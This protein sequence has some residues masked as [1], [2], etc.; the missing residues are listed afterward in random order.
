MS[1]IRNH[2]NRA[3]EMAEMA[4]VARLKGQGDDA[5]GFFRRALEFELMAIKEAEASGRVE[6]TYSVLQRSAAT[7]ALDCND[8]RGAERIVAKALAQ[9]PPTEIAE[10]LRDI[11]EQVNFRRHLELKGITLEEDELQMNLS[12]RGVGY[13]LVK[14][15]EFLNRVENTSK[16][17]FRIVERRRNKPFREKGRLTSGLKEDYELFVSVP[18]AASF[19]VTLKLG[20]PTAQQKLPGILETASIVDEFMDLM[21]LANQNKM[22]DI[23][24]RIPDPA[25]FRNFVALAKKVA[26]DGDTV[27]QVGFTAVHS[28]RQRL[29]Q[30]TRPAPDFQL[31]PVDAKLGL[32]ELV[33]VKGVLRYA[34]ATHGDSGLIKVV[35]DGGS[36]T[37]TIKVPEGMMADIVRP[38]WDSLV[39]VKGR[40]EGRVITLEDIQEE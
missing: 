27:Q 34:D 12:G 37:H 17:I 1:A 11:L 29:V 7:L 15:V 3:M 16:A 8:T 22:E 6:P 30:V 28:G 35:E 33:I 21:E 10:E 32:S 4:L 24:E 14:S 25:Y 9:D 5:D 13:G 26:P 36:K 20:R 31:P 38:M 2:H 19:S 18:R 40:R 23:K 39:I